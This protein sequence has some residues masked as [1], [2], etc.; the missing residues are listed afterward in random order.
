MSTTG[1][2]HHGRTG[3]YSYSAPSM[4]AA[5]TRRCGHACP[6]GLRG[7]GALARGRHALGA[8]LERRARAAADGGGLAPPPLP[9]RAAEVRPLCL[10]V[11][12]RLA[13]FSLYVGPPSSVSLSRSVGLPLSVSL[14]LCRSPSLCLS[15]ARALSLPLSVSAGFS[16]APRTSRLPSLCEARP[17][18]LTAWRLTA[19]RGADGG[20][21]CSAAPAG[22]EHGRRW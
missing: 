21:I 2:R 5:L 8:A 14:S 19:Q 20:G 11:V 22:A 1:V 3:R 6:T 9:R 7:G 17:G 16:V 13:L 15:C 12:L 4:A 18:P 10:S